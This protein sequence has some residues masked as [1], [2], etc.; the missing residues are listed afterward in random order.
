MTW[1][2]TV[3]T[4]P[5][6]CLTETDTRWSRTSSCTGGLASVPVAARYV[7]VV[8]GATVARKLPSRAHGGGRRPARSRLPLSPSIA[9]VL[10][11]PAATRP[12]NT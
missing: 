12:V 8:V 6:A 11:L 1:T 10:A 3:V 4:P 7:V 2:L 5:C 9:T